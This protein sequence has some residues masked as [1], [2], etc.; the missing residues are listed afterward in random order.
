MAQTLRA[1]EEGLENSERF[2]WARGARRRALEEAIEREMREL[3]KDRPPDSTQHAAG[4]AAAE[5]GPGGK[6]GGAVYDAS[7]DEEEEQEVRSV[8]MRGVWK[9][10]SSCLTSVDLV[11]VVRPVCCRAGQGAGAGPAVRLEEGQEEGG[12]GR[13]HREPLDHDLAK[14]HGAGRQA[15]VVVALWSRRTR[16]L[17][18]M[19]AS[20]GSWQW[21]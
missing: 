18:A 2:S 4:E 13:R 1:K 3:D 20:R 21:R 7:G 19:T 16:S 12:Q 10:G 6:E 17:M 5:K 14:L 15:H 8:G 9:A 11:V